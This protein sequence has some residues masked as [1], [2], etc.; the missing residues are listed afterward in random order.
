[1]R[2]KSFSLHLSPLLLLLLLAAACEPEKPTPADSP[3]TTPPAATDR[4]AFLLNEGTWGSN[5][6]EISR[7]NITRQTIDP[8]WFSHANGR[9]LGDVAQDLVLYGARLYCTVWNSGT[10][11]VIN[12]A[13]G[14]SIKQIDFA[15][16]GPR[17]IVCRDNKIYVSCYDRTVVRIDT[18]S[19]E[20]EASCPLPGMQPEQMCLC[21]DNLI[22]CNSWQYAPDGTTTLYDSTVSVVNLATFTVTDRITVGT[23]PTRIQAI[24]DDHCII[25][26]S[27]DYYNEQ[28]STKILTVGT[29]QL[30]PLPYAATAMDIRDGILYHYITTYDQQW[31]PM[32]LFYRTDLQTLQSTPILTAVNMPYAYGLSIDP[33]TGN[34]FI[35][36]SPYTATGDLY[37]YSPQGNPL[38]QTEARFY[39]KKVV[40]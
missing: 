40:F 8:D 16:R 7:L 15:S 37:I 4:I 13:S 21:G 28:A 12:P 38:W 39:P 2:T 29:K 27:G 10:L 5:N 14:K 3:D 22:V 31:N 30:T 36:N 34:L 20:I 1:M 6:A 26:C 33:T 17:Y 32:A 24:D 35:C 11:E 18:A 23:N 19:L 9:G 25:A